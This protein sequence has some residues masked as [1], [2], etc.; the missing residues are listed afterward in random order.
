MKKSHILIVLI[1]LL[2]CVAVFVGA[3]KIFPKT[4][5]PLP[6]S[7]AEPAFDVESALSYIKTL[8]TSFTHRV[9]GNPSYRDAAL[10]L[11]EELAVLGL[12]VSIQEFDMVIESEE[13]VGMNVLG[14]SPGKT[15]EII[16]V[17]GH[18]DIPP[19]VAEGAGDNASGVGITL[20]LARIFSQQPHEKTMIFMPNGAEEYG[21]WGVRSFIR[22][23]DERDKIVAVVDIDFSHLFEPAYFLPL[24]AGTHRG[25]TPPTL[26]ETTLQELEKGDLPIFEVMPVF[27]YLDRSIPIAVVD[28]GTFL[29]A[30]IPAV[31]LGVSTDV[32]NYND[33][34]YHTEEDRFEYLTPEAISALG[35]ASERLLLA[36]D[37]STLPVES[38]YYLKVSKQSYVPGTIIWIAQLLLFVPLFL[39]AIFL[40]SSLTGTS[41]KSYIDEAKAFFGTFIALA[42]GYI[43][44]LI[45]PEIGLMVKYELYPATMKDPVLYNPQWV[46][47]LLTYGSMV[48]VG[49]IV[50]FSPLFKKS[51][52]DHAGERAFL[53]AALS[54]IVLVT[55]VVNGFSASLLLFLPAVLWIWIGPGKSAI[56]TVANLVLLLLGTAVFSALLIFFPKVYYIGPIYWYLTMAASFGLVTPIA[57]ILFLLT[58]A[59]FIRLIRLS[60]MRRAGV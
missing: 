2:V 10:W 41:K 28:A 50:A 39:T 35:S 18:F 47:L 9:T 24:F 3:L 58:C 53:M 27:E 51:G 5:S 52:K 25:Y 30:G 37:E 45:L 8:S 42:V 49:V 44:L 34:Y 56:R 48:V 7:S 33:I 6:P 55:M 11:A 16:V 21:M 1:S 4:V 14:T 17:T 54:G 13:V 43:V 59:V 19:Y 36:L 12:E 60:F 46:A 22:D 57:V 29:G 31:N 32:P 38:M 26:R 20:E 23:F 40:I 15:D